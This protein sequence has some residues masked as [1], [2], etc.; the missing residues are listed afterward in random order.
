MTDEQ[1]PIEGLVQP[2][3]PATDPHALQAK[4][5]DHGTEYV[6]ACGKWDGWAK[7]PA[8]TRFVRNQHAEHQRDVAAAEASDEQ[9]RLRII[10][11]DTTP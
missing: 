1:P 5:T 10:E 11:G 9:A 3:T 8:S 6:C 7:G 4:T 2:F